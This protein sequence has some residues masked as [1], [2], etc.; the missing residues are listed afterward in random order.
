VGYR[1]V[2]SLDLLTVRFRVEKIWKGDEA[3]EIRMLTGTK[4]NGD[5]T[6]TMT[7]CD[8]PFR[9]GKKYLLYAYGPSEKLITGACSRT[10]PLEYA[11][12]EMKGLD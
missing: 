4:Y 8:Y 7:S 12:A 5:G 1:S 3:K 2:I 6:Y 9:L 11:E 10:S